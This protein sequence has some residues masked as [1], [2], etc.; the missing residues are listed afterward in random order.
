MGIITQGLKPPVNRHRQLYA[1]C[2]A[3]DYPNPQVVNILLMDLIHDRI[4]SCQ[5]F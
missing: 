3:A 1:P 4:P 2:A 5:E